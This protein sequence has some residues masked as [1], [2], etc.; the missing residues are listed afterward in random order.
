MNKLFRSGCNVNLYV[1]SQEKMPKR[2]KD[3]KKML[4]ITNNEHKIRS[5]NYSHVF[6]FLE[7]YYMHFFKVMSYC[8][9]IVKLLVAIYCD[10]YN[11]VYPIS[12]HIKLKI[13]D[14]QVESCYV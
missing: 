8:W 1:C 4:F 13:V 10:Q 6:C 9:L 7:R 5:L 11:I 3:K 2:G 14:T 12:I